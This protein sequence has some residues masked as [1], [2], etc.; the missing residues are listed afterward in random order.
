MMKAA[1]FGQ[2]ARIM[3]ATCSSAVRAAASS[4]CWNA[5][6]SAAQPRVHLLRVAPD[7][8]ARPA[9]HH[10]HHVA[11][12]NSFVR[13]GA[14]LQW[15]NPVGIAVKVLRC[16]ISR[17]RAGEAGWWWLRWWRWRRLRSTEEKKTSC[18]EHGLLPPPVLSI[19]IIISGDSNYGRHTYNRHPPGVG[20]SGP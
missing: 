4:G 19:I 1:S 14:W 11:S 3:S 6:R 12:L 9:L 15:E 13:T 8:A 10:H 7:H 18:S 20:I 5:W 16:G 17:Q 2:R